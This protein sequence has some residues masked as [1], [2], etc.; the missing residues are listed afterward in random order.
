LQASIIIPVRD[1]S[2]NVGPICEAFATL[3]NTDPSVSEVIFVDDHSRD[4]TRDQINLCTANFPFVKSVIQNDQRGK[5]AAIKSGFQ[6][7]RSDVLVMMDGDQQYSPFDIHR[8]L[9]P[10]LA[11]SADL[12]VGRGSNHHSS[13]IRRVLSR[14][15]QV[16]FRCAF[17]LPVSSPNEGFKAIVRG[18]FE[19]LEIIAN[20]FD[21]DIELL[22][23]AKRHLLRITEVPVERRE[24]YAGRSKVQVFPTVARFCSRMARLWFSQRKWL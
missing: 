3:L 11:G 17:R 15:F 19:E 6:K 13:I 24:R 1:E 7:S 12:V 8:L 23:K 14:S 9:E 2:S 16:I 18:K 10:I 22:V 4:A 21:F 20:G 5:G